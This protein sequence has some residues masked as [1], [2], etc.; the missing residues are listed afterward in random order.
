MAPQ[1]PAQL[2]SAAAESV[3]SLNHATLSPGRAGWEEPSDAYDVIGGLDRAAS[4]LPQA[5]DQV[6]SLL[7]GLAADGHLGSDRGT[8]TA[9]MAEAR[10]ALDEARAAAQRL[11]AALTRAHSATSHLAWQD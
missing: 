7:S 5:L 3:R 2:A 11:N 10:L 4:M 1:T 6:W 9:D 8:V